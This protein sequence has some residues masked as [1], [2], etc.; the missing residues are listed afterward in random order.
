MGIQAR[1]VSA[2]ILKTSEA[3]I[4]KRQRTTEPPSVYKRNWM[5]FPKLPMLA[6]LGGIK[7]KICLVD[8]HFYWLEKQKPY[9]ITKYK[10][11][12][13]RRRSNFVQMAAVLKTMKYI[14]LWTQ[15]KRLILIQCKYIYWYRDFNLKHCHSS[16]GC[17]YLFGTFSQSH[18]INQNQHV[19]V[20]ALEDYICIQIWLYSI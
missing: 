2:Q 9:F 13:L 11:T 20:W 18:Y 4:L 12:A 6:R 7:L 17:I 16:Y 14:E 15:N 5:F 10:V 3:E 19:P 1:S 8:E